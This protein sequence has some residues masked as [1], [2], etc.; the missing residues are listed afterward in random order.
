MENL[1]FS[2]GDLHKIVTPVS[3]FMVNEANSIAKG[4][5]INR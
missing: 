4:Y 2:P 5:I 3:G 1:K